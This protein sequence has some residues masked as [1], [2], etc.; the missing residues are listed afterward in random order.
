MARRAGP[1]YANATRADVSGGGGHAS[2]R[3]TRIVDGAPHRSHQGGRS[4]CS[5]RA[6]DE[7]NGQGPSPHPAHARGKTASSMRD[8]IAATVPGTTD[9]GGIVFGVM[10]PSRWR[11]ARKGSLVAILALEAVALAGLGLN[12]LVVG[13]ITGP[14]IDDF[15]A[16]GGHRVFTLIGLG[17]ASW[18]ASAAFVVIAVAIVTERGYAGTPH[19]PVWQAIVGGGI[20]L[21]LGW[22]VLIAV[23]DVDPGTA[24]RIAWCIGLALS[25]WATVC[26]WLELRGRIRPAS[27]PLPPPP[28]RAQIGSAG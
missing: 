14:S 19:T 3:G 8:H 24:S 12:W 18:A 7:Q 28:E 21:Q 6:Q 25:A 22:L 10:R 1:A 27:T 13:S 5:S 4:G 20:L 9:I 26:L 16:D 2:H 23:G 11:T 17:I 15:V